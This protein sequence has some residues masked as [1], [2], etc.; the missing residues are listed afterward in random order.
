MAVR[1][2]A[3]VWKGGINEREKERERK[4]TTKNWKRTERVSQPSD[5]VV[6]SQ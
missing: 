5:P 3:S 2:M 1:W 4:G 6:G